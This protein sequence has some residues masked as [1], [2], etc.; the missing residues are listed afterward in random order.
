[1]LELIA[2]SICEGYT[3]PNFLNHDLNFLNLFGHVCTRLLQFIKLLQANS[4]CF[5]DSFHFPPKIMRI[6]VNPSR[7]NQ[8]IFAHIL[9]L[10]IA[11]SNSFIFNPLPFHQSAFYLE[12]T[13]K[14]A[15]QFPLEFCLPMLS[16]SK[17]RT[18]RSYQHDVSR[19]CSTNHI[20]H[21]LNST[22]Y[23]FTFNPN[24]LANPIAWAGDTV[25]PAKAWIGMSIRSYVQVL[26][27][28]PFK[29]V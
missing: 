10:S 15:P 11:P 18:T 21:P 2:L 9:P 20:H 5:A 12:K 17:L 24:S 27:S 25:H 7:L 4:Q 26:M 28:V 23:S 3:I 8:S 22:C 13:K 16:D 29:I 14:T 6:G 1:M 19:Y